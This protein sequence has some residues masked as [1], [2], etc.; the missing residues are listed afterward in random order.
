MRLWLSHRR[1]TSGFSIRGIEEDHGGIQKKDASR[2]GKE[3]KQEIIPV[4]IKVE[5][6]PKAGGSLEEEEVTIGLVRRLGHDIVKKKEANLKAQ[7]IIETMPRRL[8]T[9]IA[10]YEQTL[11]IKNDSEII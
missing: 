3:V 4:N 11:L 5:D 8:L 7:C 1:S 9:L 2:G 6:A 10:S